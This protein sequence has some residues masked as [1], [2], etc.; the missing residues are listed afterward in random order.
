MTISAAMMSP[1]TRNPPPI[2]DSIASSAEY[3]VFVLA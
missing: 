1:S 2:S 3:I